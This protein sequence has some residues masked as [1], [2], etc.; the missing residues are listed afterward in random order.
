MVEKIEDVKKD[1][2]KNQPLE[3]INE[4]TRELI[5]KELKS[6]EVNPLPEHLED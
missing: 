1:E 2:E 4:S 3:R 6:K 5:K